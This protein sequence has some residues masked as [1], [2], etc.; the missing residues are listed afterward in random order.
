MK[1]LLLFIGTILA[2]QFSFSQYNIT[3]LGS[4]AVGNNGYANIWGYAQGNK[5]YALL[6]CTGT[7]PDTLSAACAIIDVTNPTTPNLLFTVLG[8]R[9]T[10][11][12]IRTWGHYAYVTTE[13]A[14]KTFGVTIV[15]LQYLPDSIVTKQYTA[16]NLIGNVHALHIDDGYLYLYGSNNP[17]SFGGALILNLQDPWNPTVAGAYSDKYVHDG[18][19]RNNKM[20]SGEIFDGTF[21]IVDVTNKSTPVVLNTQ[22][23]PFEFTHNTWLSTDNNYLYTTDEEEEAF[24]ASYD[25]S[26]PLEIVEKDRYRRA[27]HNGAIP[28]NTYILNDQGVTGTNTDWLTTS[29]YT[30][31]VTIVDAHKPDN[32]VEVGHYDTSPFS[33]GGF[34]GAWGVYPYLPSGNL[35]VSDMQLGLFVLK[36]DFQRACYLEGV[37][38]DVNTNL[39]ISNATVK[40]VANGTVE[41]SKVNGIYKSGIVTQGVNNVEFSAPGYV[42]QTLQPNLVRE[43][44]VTLNVALQPSGVGIENKSNDDYKVFPSI[45][46]K[47][48]YIQ[49]AESKDLHLVLLDINGK[50]VKELDVNG[51]SIS[52]DFEEINSG[53]YILQVYHHTELKLSQKLI[54]E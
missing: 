4:L 23:T 30:E 45:V 32:L 26:N 47:E 8:P 22:K 41:S 46:K 44:T 17:Q 54:K 35:L 49:Q 7:G 14:S 53:H 28:H 1:K 9:S 3:K 43:Q 51:K 6:G 24:V 39:P 31:G 34:S 38:T 42:T 37:I 29:Y 13:H 40:F 36:P 2:S 15:D 18:I 21:S 52:I 50:L 5:E 11:R 25:V 16:N 33:G 20:Y 12:E 19:V 10:W 48:L 27:N